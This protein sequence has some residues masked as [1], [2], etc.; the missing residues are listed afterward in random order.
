MHESI[1]IG[2][3]RHTRHLETTKE[4]KMV[5]IENMDK[6]TYCTLCPFCN[7]DGDCLIIP[8]AELQETFEEQ[9]ALCPLKE[10]QG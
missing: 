2:T 1:T 3:D 7:V 6:P 4:K 8:G 10:V 9:Y 5:L